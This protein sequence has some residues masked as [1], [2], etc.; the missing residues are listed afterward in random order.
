MTWY[1]VGSKALSQTRFNLGWREPKDIDIW[2]SSRE[3]SS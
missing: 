2:S 3:G 1:V